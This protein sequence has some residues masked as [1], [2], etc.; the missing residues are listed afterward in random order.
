MSEEEKKVREKQRKK[1]NNI[2]KYNYM[3]INANDVWNA[4]CVAVDMA[5]REKSRKLIA[6]FRHH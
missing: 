6:V 2:N 5:A 3:K 4:N 1:A